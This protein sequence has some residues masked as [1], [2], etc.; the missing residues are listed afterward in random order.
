MEVCFRNLCRW[1]RS[2]TACDWSIIPLQWLESLAGHKP[3]HLPGDL[4]QHII[5]QSLPVPLSRTRQVSSHLHE[6][7]DVSF[8]LRTIRISIKMAHGTKISITHSNYDDRQR[9]RWSSTDSLMCF[10]HVCYQPIRD[11]QKNKVIRGAMRALSCYLGH[12]TND[13][14]KI[15]WTIQLNN[16]GCSLIC[17]QDMFNASDV[18][19]GRCQ[20]EVKEILKI[21]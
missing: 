13:W 11:D 18:W 2:K 4:C 6:L 5:Q 19:V 14:R 3:Q 8:K 20:T 21:K 7:D 12:F 10:F 15:G 1:G 16:F 17:R 9:K